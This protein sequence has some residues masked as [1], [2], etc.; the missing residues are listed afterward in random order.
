[1]LL[2]F[3]LP[4]TNLS[5]GMG[6]QMGLYLRSVGGGLKIFTGAD[7]DSGGHTVLLICEKRD[8]LLMQRKHKNSSINPFPL[9]SEVS[10]K[11]LFERLKSILCIHRLRVPVVSLFSK[12]PQHCDQCLHRNWKY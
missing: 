2:I 7:C 9:D 3:N 4:I 1:M 5:D 12:A 11:D 6:L 10:Q 8:T